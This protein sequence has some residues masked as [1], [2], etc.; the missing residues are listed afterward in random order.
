[1]H[2]L[3]DIML[4]YNVML[5]PFLALQT[6]KQQ[7]KQGNSEK[8]SCPGNSLSC[9]VNRFV[10]NKTVG[11]I[12]GAWCFIVTAACCIMGV[13][14]TDPLTLALNIITPVVLI[15]LGLILPVIAGY[16]KK[17]GKKVA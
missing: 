9:G 12:F 13:Y 7:G 15:A 14:S 2:D 16:E 10:K 1:M 3:S 6:K 8:D 17:S 4:P 5:I 11:I